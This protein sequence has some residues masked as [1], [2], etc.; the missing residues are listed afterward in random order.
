[1]AFMNMSTAKMEVKM[2]T[3][4]INSLSRSH[5]LATISAGIGLINGL[6]GCAAVS[7]F[8]LNGKLTRGFEDGMP[9]L[10]NSLTCFATI[11]IAMVAAAFGFIA[12]KE[13]QSERNLAWVGFAL[14]TLYVVNFVLFSYFIASAAT[15]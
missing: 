14:N 5:Q 9:G 6:V 10:L 1:M 7:S 11:P 8:Y 4:S 12:L 2:Q 15:H 3:P 13:S